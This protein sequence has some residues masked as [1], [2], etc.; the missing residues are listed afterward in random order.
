VNRRYLAAQSHHNEP[1][2]SV[3]SGLPR[4]LVA[5]ACLLFIL[6]ELPL[7]QT[8]WIEDES[9]Y[10]D[11]AWTFSREGQIR[12]SMYPPTDLGSIVDVRPPA[13]PIAFGQV[14]KMLGLGIWQARLLPFLGAL[15]AIILTWLLGL[16]LAGPWSGAIGALMVATDNMLF[17]AARTARPEGIIAFLNALTFLLFLL[18][19][20]RNSWLSALAAGIVAGAAM[21]FHIN[22]V[23]APLAM[24]L[25]ALYE[26][27]FAIWRKP[28][29]WIFFIA[30]LFC[31]APY[32][33]WI[34]A[35]RIHQQAY[36]EMQAL[37]TVVQH[38]AGRLRGEWMRYSDF[39][40]LG[41]QKL[42]LPIRL[43]ARAPVVLVILAGAGVLFVY[44]RRLFW[45]LG[46]LL[47][48]CM[49][50]WFYLAN[51]NVRYTAVA[52]PVFALIVASAAVSFATSRKRR[53]VAVAAC[54]L[55]A[56][57]Q[58]AG[59]AFLTWR[60]RDADYNRLATELR[61][62]IPA[63]ESVYGANTFWL[64][65]ND[66]RYYSYDRS[67]FDYAIANLKPRYLILYD[68]VMIDGSGFGADDFR[69][70]RTKATAFV[71]TYCEKTAV[72]SNPFYGDL[73]I[74]RVR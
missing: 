42:P 54:L 52:A 37:G 32:V 27:R 21:N 10:A 67:P 43:P 46:L 7:F 18:A 61:N 47:A 36:R 25:W 40:G 41:N 64:A 4:V 9:S 69:E 72:I 50:W 29:V 59:N 56:A 8:R 2:S 16:H 49:G 12:M 28:V 11:A 58:I 51:K 5:L 73:E 1:T 39:I 65:L 45:L 30:A 33:F 57:N 20:R 19:M 13:M 48:A 63:G 44:Q 23:I 70:V 3:S 22:G 31:L 6:Q 62:A 68:R 71:H 55:Y 60:F 38:A 53:W 34:N 66:R 15:G 26:Y 14:F 17:M 74:Y 24:G 35:D